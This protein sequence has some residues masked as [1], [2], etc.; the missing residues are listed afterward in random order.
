MKKQI[1][2]TEAE[3]VEKTERTRVQRLEKQIREFQEYG[4]EST[5]AGL[6]VKE[7][8]NKALV[9]IIGDIRI[10][11]SEF[12]VADYSIEVRQAF[13]ISATVY[14]RLRM[15]NYRDS[16]RADDGRVFTPLN[17][18]IEVSTPGTGRDVEASIAFAQLLTDLNTF[19]VRVKAML[20]DRKFY[21]LYTPDNK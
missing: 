12:D 18:V 10:N 8:V 7:A 5:G 17:L 20:M 15:G 19:A 1:K 21:D 14:I 11:K 4:T 13:S 6:V 16:V 3:Q 2:L 9:P